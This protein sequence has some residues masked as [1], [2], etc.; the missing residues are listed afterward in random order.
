MNP[1]SYELSNQR[2][3][4]HIVATRALSEVQRNAAM[5]EP[6]ECLQTPHADCDQSSGVP[7]STTRIS[8]RES[9]NKC[10]SDSH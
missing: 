7:P 3:T 6:L 4:E 5:I 8:I 10:E 2:C 9:G 1:I